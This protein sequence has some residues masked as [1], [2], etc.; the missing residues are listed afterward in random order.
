MLVENRVQ[1]VIIRPRIPFQMRGQ[2][3]IGVIYPFR[4]VISL[5][6]LDRPH[7]GSDENGR[8]QDRIQ[9]GGENGGNSS[10]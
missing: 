2:P 6:E 4:I 10:L 9:R 1:V 5:P 8:S 3:R 7:V